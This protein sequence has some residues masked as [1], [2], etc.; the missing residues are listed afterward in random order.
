[1]ATQSDIQIRRNRTATITM[2]VSG[3]P[4]WAGLFSRFYLATSVGG[5]I[6]LDLDATP[7]GG[8][9]K[10]TATLSSANIA[11]LSGTY[12]YEVILYKTDLSYLKTVLYGKCKIANVI[13]V[14][15]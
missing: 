5:N 11:N 7:D 15:T 4:S 3:V 12:Y 6:L 10:I 13:K 9:N 2:D 1:M 14:M 8:N